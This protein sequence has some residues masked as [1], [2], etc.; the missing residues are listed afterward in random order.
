MK[1]N[2]KLLIPAGILLLIP[3]QVQV[4][5]TIRMHLIL[6]ING[7]FG[8]SIAPLSSLILIVLIQLPLILYCLVLHHRSPGKAFYTIGFTLLMLPHLRT[9][10]NPLTLISLLFFASMIPL[11]F[12]QKKWLVLI[13]GLLLLA[14][15]A[16][17]LITAFPIL[18]MVAES[19]STDFFPMLWTW[20]IAPMC[21][22]VAYG[23]I[24][25]HLG[26]H[27]LTNTAP[28]GTVHPA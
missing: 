15:T 4:F 8:Q 11:C 28:D 14:M 25:W 17:Q 19:Y 20:I 21:F 23:L 27:A 7:R 16:G 9:L 3:L 6:M 26:G 22:Q 24:W 18:S 12:S 1:K 10:S 13:A 5:E 2:R